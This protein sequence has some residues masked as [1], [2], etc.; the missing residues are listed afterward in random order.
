MRISKNLQQRIEEV[1]SEKIDVIPYNPHW[2]KMFEEE[3]E[4]LKNRFPK[5]INRIEY[6]GS[7]AAPGLS[8]KPIVDMIVEV[9][10]VNEVKKEVVPVLTTV[11]YEYF[12]RPTIGNKPPYYAWFIKRNSKGKRTHHIHL[13]EVDSKLWDRIYFR[14]YL[15]E[16][17]KEAGDYEKL[18]LELL[19]KHPNNREVYT[20]AKTDFITALTEKAK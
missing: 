4:A 9:S 6:F 7:T 15:R 2:P 14:D 18:K 1:V 20:R 10:N 17:S 5:I 19:E 16:Y 3:A 11:G 12:W 8:A 13:V